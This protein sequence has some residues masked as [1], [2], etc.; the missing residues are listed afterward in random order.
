MVSYIK[1]SGGPWARS[2]VYSLRPVIRVPSLTVSTYRYRRC[3]E[4]SIKVLNTHY[5]SIIKLVFV[6]LSFQSSPGG[7]G[8]ASPPSAGAATA[9]LS[10]SYL[11][12]MLLS[13]VDPVVLLECFGVGNHMKSWSEIHREIEC[14]VG[15][16]TYGM[17]RFGEV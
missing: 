12:N 4:A 2:Q 5:P 17:E 1:L 11:Y 3:L 7:P 15:D 13:M 10:S 6:H 16:K 14:T 8:S 9:W